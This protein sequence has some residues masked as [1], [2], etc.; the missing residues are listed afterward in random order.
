[1][2][3]IHNFSAG[4]AVLPVSVVEA[5]SKAV[6][7][8]KN[9]GM[10][11]MEMSHRSKAIVDIFDEAKANC[12]QIMNL[13]END[14]DVIFLGGGASTQFAMIPLNFLKTKADYISTGAW[15]KKAVEEAKMVGEVNL[16]G[17]SSDE[18]FNYIPKELNFSPDANYV[19]ICSN[20]TIYGTRWLEFPKVDVPY[21]CDMSSDIFSREINFSQFDMIY[22]GAQKNIGPSGATLVVIKKSFLTEHGKSGLMTMMSY[23]THTEKDSMFNTPP[24]LPVFVINETFKWILD[25]GLA[26]LE[27]INNRKAGKI[28]SAIDS[29]GGFY[30]GA[31]PDKNDR[32]VMNITFNL[33]NPELESKFVSEAKTKNL[34]GLK[35][36]RSVGGVRASIYNACPEASID[37]LVEFMEE[38]RLLNS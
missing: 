21:V 16:A 18:N 5:T 25:Q 12:L 10:G 20:N 29:S 14:Y 3:R 26:N 9:L 28:Y 30:T 37:A 36:H 32:S 33:Q 27:K 17:D 23:K 19:H 2:N 13:S 11:I 8:Y 6:L 22:A 4:P 34:D 1:M 35:G 24:V 7:E 31:V 38:F 15:A